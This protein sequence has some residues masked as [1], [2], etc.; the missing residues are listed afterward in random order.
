MAPPLA[1]LWL[2]TSGQALTTSLPEQL[3]PIGGT[4]YFIADD[5]SHGRALWRS[6]GTAAG[7]VLVKDINPDDMG[8]ETFISNLS[9]GNGTLYFSADDGSQGV[10]LWRSDGTETGTVM[11]KDINPGSGSAFSIYLIPF[12]FSY[13]NGHIYF[14]AD[15]GSHGFELWRSDGTDA[16]TGMVKDIK[17]GNSSSSDG[18][19][20]L[21]LVNGVF[22]FEADDGSNGVEVWRSDGTATGTVMVQNIAPGASSS[23]PYGFPTRLVTAGPFLFFA[24]DDTSTGIELWAWPIPQGISPSNTT[25]LPLIFKNA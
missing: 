14:S 5:G 20:P 3:T 7:T 11:V 13:F 25:Y 21:T 10:E 17:P 16:G 6:D 15:D 18:Y 23:A 2:R 22:Y 1:Q 24:A 9:N 8:D 12:Q 19:Q 4:L